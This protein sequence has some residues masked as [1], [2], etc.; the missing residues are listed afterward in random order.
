MNEKLMRLMGAIKAQESGGNY[1]AINQR[2]GAFGAYQ[3]MPQ[4]LDGSW[5]GRA[6]RANFG[7]DYEALGR[8]VTQ[9]E[10]LANPRLQ[11]QIA[12]YH[13]GKLQAKYG[14]QGAANAW[15]SGSPKGGNKPP[16]KGEPTINQYS[17]QVLGRM[18]SQQ[19]GSKDELRALLASR[20]SKSGG[21]GGGGATGSKD[22]LRALLSKAKKTDQP[23]P[24]APNF[25][26]SMGA[27][28]NDIFGGLQQ[29]YY[30]TKDAVT[31]G[32]EYDQ[33]TQQELAGKKIYEDARRANGETGLD[34]G[35]LLGG[36][37]A[38]AP[39]APLAKGLQAGQK[40]LSVAG[41]RMVAQN[42]AV[43]AGVG[44][45]SFAEN[46]DRRLQNVGLGAALGGV[47]A[48]GATKLEQGLRSMAA[49]GASTT[50]A[51][52]SELSARAS[53]MVDDALR[54]NGADPINTPPNIRQKLVDEVLDGLS[55]NKTATLE[56]IARS[57]TFQRLGIQG[58]KA[59]T[60]GRPEIARA[61]RELAKVDG[62]GRPLNDKYFEDST[63]L[64][65]Q[66]DDL[67][68]G[69]GGTAPDKYQA[70]QDAMD[71][72]RS[73]DAAKQTVVRDLYNTARN[74]SGN[75]LP[76]NSARFV[77][78]VSAEL[79]R[80]GLGTF[81][82]G[83]VRQILGGLFDGR[84]VLTLAK[85]EELVK[86]LNARLRS[87]TD[88]DKRYALGIVR[89]SLEREVDDTLADFG[90]RLLNSGNQDAIQAW[91]SARQAASQRFAAIERTP[92]LKTAL[93]DV[94]PDNLFEKLILR[95]NVRDLEALSKELKD[96]PEVLNG[97]RQQVVEHISS[98]AIS[99]VN[100]QFSP[101]G[102]SDALKSIG[103][104]RL[105]L[106]FSPQELAKL[107]DIEA[108][109]KYL[110]SQPRN[111]NINNSNT[112]SVL[113]NYMNGVL[114]AP[115]IRQTVTKPIME[116]RQG[117]QVNNALQ[118]G[119]DMIKGRPLTPIEQ[120]ILNRFGVIIDK[121]G[122]IVRVGSVSQP[123][124]NQ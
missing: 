66:M 120:D 52:R 27:G 47:A 37:I 72:L 101:K 71:A 62:A 124:S 85:K 29:G 6:P 67:A 75:E 78:N 88:G 33:F 54:A 57:A 96:Q 49:K 1:G 117:Q 63:V 110:I 15:Y 5:G 32:N 43:G 41:A 40:V 21:G 8:D 35:R 34:W 68:R 9:Q 107:K 59:Q 53:Q 111:A 36:M 95:G 90:G 119:L 31:G 94:A 106:M 122:Q 113:L 22:E 38:T 25:L 121:S 3:I 103:D 98:K 42:A 83:D 20:F 2:T 50:G 4:N 28:M 81:L 108:A 17:A 60:S 109:A 23:K 7:W 118:G 64:A 26:E 16:A 80:N 79:E 87:T 18:G 100:G 105:S 58:T 46:S 112:A 114:N 13:L 93:D 19:T 56:S 45:T 74:A 10:L 44:G 86:I 82:A 30:Y 48:V 73:N 69:T 65:T 77:N 102:M 11:D 24:E 89:D 116:W 91:Q 12:Q 97:I 51:T 76:L 55:R 92:A 14:D 115:W 104:R 61:E 39:V 123:P 99:S 70:M 84:G